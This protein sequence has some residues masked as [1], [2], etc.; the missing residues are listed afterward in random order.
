MEP[1]LL[2]A[3]REP[4]VRPGILGFSH[5]AICI[6]CTVLLMVLGVMAIGDIA[7]LMGRLRSG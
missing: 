4:T 5:V 1:Y 3:K 2:S 7:S 6:V